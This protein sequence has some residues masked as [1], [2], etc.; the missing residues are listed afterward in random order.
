MKGI[1]EFPQINILFKQYSDKQWL[2]NLTWPAAFAL[3]LIYTKW[4][5][6]TNQKNPT[7]NPVSKLPYQRKFKCMQIRMLTLHDKTDR[8]KMVKKTKRNINSNI[9][10]LTNITLLIG[11]RVQP[12]GQDTGLRVK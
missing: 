2:S 4:K 6:P 12:S 1:P 7:N 5:E 3:L 8:H 10:Y 11:C 9:S